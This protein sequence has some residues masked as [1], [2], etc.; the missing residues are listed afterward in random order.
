MLLVSND[1]KRP[2]YSQIIDDLS[3]IIVTHYYF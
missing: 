3:K 2:I 1:N